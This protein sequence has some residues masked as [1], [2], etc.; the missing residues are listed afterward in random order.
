MRVPCVPTTA[1]RMLIA[2]RMS[3]RAPVR[4]LVP[5][6]VAVPAALATNMAGIVRIAV[7]VFHYTPPRVARFYGL[8]LQPCGEEVVSA[9]GPALRL[10]SSLVGTLTPRQRESFDA[11]PHHCEYLS[12]RVH[13]R[14][15]F[16][17]LIIHR[18]GT[19]IFPG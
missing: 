3:V 5:M 2:M 15:L 18:H 13:S 4:L 11:L 16:A 9:L 1:M 8:Y 19:R 17:R 7:H 6:I 14:Y 12:S 10:S